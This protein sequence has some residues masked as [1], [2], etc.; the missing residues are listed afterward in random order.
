MTTSNNDPPKKRRGRPPGAKNKPKGAKARKEAAKAKQKLFRANPNLDPTAPYNSSQNNGINNSE[1][2][3]ILV[4][5]HGQDKVDKLQEIIEEYDDRVDLPP[6]RRLFAQECARS[7]HLTGFMNASEAYKKSGYSA[8]NENTAAASSCWLLK[9]AKVRE[10]ILFY[11]NNVK[12]RTA[13]SHEYVID[14]LEKN[15][16]KAAQ[17]IPVLDSNGNPTGE[18]SYQGAVVNKAWE[19]IGK[20]HGMWPDKRLIDVKGNISVENKHSFNMNL[21]ITAEDFKE[22]PLEVRKYV[23]EVLKKKKQA[24][25][26]SQKS[27]ELKQTPKEVQNLSQIPVVIEN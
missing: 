18:Y 16:E 24:F 6:R 3:H 8:P 13:I 5:E 2:C 22:A 27:I 9:N 25:L 12:E 15:A 17:A 19:L 26:D 21:S 20:H 1:N 23:V 7:W 14:K 10:L 11:L 4:E